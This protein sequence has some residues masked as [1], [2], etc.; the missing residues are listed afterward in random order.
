VKRS[1]RVMRLTRGSQTF[2]TQVVKC[3][4][5]EQCMRSVTKQI[6]EMLMCRF[7]SRAGHVFD[8]KVMFVTV[9]DPRAD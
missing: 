1:R 2:V 6:V 3:V 9:S 8:N 5:Q 7:M 4:V